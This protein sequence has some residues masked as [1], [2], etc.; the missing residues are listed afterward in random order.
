MTRMKIFRFGFVLALVLVSLALISAYGS[1]D[2]P[3]RD[4]HH[5]GVR[6]EYLI[7]D[8]T[9]EEY[10]EQ[11]EGIREQ[12]ERVA[13]KQAQQENLIESQT[14]EIARLRREAEAFKRQQEYRSAQRAQAVMDLSALKSTAVV[15]EEEEE[16]ENE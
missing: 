14:E 2:D 11:Q 6:E 1:E 3:C 16:P 12:Q 15:E 7:A 13:I 5:H 10:E 4:S 8:I 9:Q